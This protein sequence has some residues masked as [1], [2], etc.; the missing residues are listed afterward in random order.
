VTHLFWAQLMGATLK[1]ATDQR[2]GHDV[3]ILSR[4]LQTHVEL[5]FKYLVVKTDMETERTFH[6]TVYSP[7]VIKIQLLE[8]CKHRAKDSQC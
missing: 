5:I 3:T 7:L 6:I 1:L 8:G 2:K 4:K